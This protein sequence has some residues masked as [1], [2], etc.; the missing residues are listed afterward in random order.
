M[1]AKRAVIYVR[2]ATDKTQTASLAIQTKRC[3][4]WA[5][6]AR[7]TVIGEYQETKSGISASLPVLNQAVESAR[8]QHAIVVCVDTSR[9]GRRIDVVASRIE[10]MRQVGI[11]VIFLEV[12]K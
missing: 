3:R 8:I 12:D 9:L 5:K 4:A 1:S 6:K 2:I 11:I 10:A 7:M